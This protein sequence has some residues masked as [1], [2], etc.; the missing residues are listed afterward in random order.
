MPQIRYQTST[1]DSFGAPGVYVKEL[2]VSAPIRGLFRGTT[3][4]VGECVRGPVNRVI[5]CDSYQRFLDIFGGR[6][7]GVNGGTLRGKV[8]W[9]LQNRRWGRFY[10][11]RA[12]AAAAAVASFT[13]ETAAG[14]GGTAVMRI[15]ASS[16][17]L[18]G[19]DIQ[20]KVSAA[21]DGT[22]TKFNLTIKLYGK[23]FLYENLNINGAA[24][25]N[26][27]LVVG[28]DDATVIRLTKLADGR[29]VNNAAATDGADADGFVNVGES[30]ASF[31]SVAGTD[32]VIA[33]GDFTGT[34]KA[35]E[36][37]HAARGVDV[38]LVAGRSNT[39]I[40]TK[41]Y[42][43][44]PTSNSSFWLACPDSETVTHTAWNTEVATIRHRR[45]FPVFNSPYMIDPI[46]SLETI[47]EP[48]AQLASI[49]SQT[50]PDVHP[51]VVETAEL[52]VGITRLYN[53]LS[54]AV[55]DSLDLNGSTY[56]NKDVDQSNNNV[57]L[58]G[59]GRTADLSVNNS[60]ID[61]ERSKIYL[62]EGLA[63]RM[64]G[65]EKKPNTPMARAKRKAEFEGWLTELAESGRFVD[66]TDD[67][68]PRF[69]V[70]NSGEV[71]SDADRAAGIQRDLVRIRL[72]P[73]NLYLQ[74]QVEAGTDVTITEQ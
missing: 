20:F 48:H 17:G 60:Q 69:E 30:V 73:K 7:Y 24:D 71:N 36:V 45:I 52:N 27:A 61:G 2:A 41:I 65:D 25:D 44:A 68:T 63:Q 66:T 57:W 38:K 64:R 19:N 31:T 53:E 5:L 1:S 51:G 47:N 10:V 11:C 39:A 28:N 21:S 26:L 54:D 42:A 70:K 23:Q 12:A 72:I 40:K 46:T 34:D 18:W 4:F 55:R 22:A 49:L 9:A 13:V 32:G 56:L 43:L 15:D 6:D 67:G 58:F 35:M 50:E 16:P 37:M 8:W 3:G 29:P 14:G 62:I 33:D 59:N 74:L